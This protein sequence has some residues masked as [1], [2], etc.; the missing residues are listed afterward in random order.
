[1]APVKGGCERASLGRT[2][3]SHLPAL[4]VNT[5]DIDAMV[6]KCKEESCSRNTDCRDMNGAITSV[7]PFCR[8]LSCCLYREC[9]LRLFEMDSQ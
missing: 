8:G 4:K 2:S 7:L 6:G 9:S 3:S 1:M 5:G